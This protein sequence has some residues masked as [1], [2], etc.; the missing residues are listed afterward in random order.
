MQNT[1]QK[2]EKKQIPAAETG[3]GISL[4]KN[5]SL[6]SLKEEYINSA[7]MISGS[8]FI[9]AGSEFILNKT[10]EAAAA[11]YGMSLKTYAKSIDPVM[12]FLLY[13]MI[14]IHLIKSV[15]VSA[16][17]YN[18]GSAILSAGHDS[19]HAIDVTAIA[20]KDG[21]GDA[22][23][24]DIDNNMV[25]P[26]PVKILYDCLVA[27]EEI[28]DLYSPWRI[29]FGS[30]GMKRPVPNEW[31]KYP[32]EIYSDK[33]NHPEIYRMWQHRQHLHLRIRKK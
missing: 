6:E 13:E 5:I 16:T 3:P 22:F 10:A 19:G 17:Y 25:E 8:R 27:R 7:D 21:T 31:N 29:L 2:N 28:L 1:D 20:F 9:F 33:K 14:Q 23:F 24:R 18:L 32:L 12:I 30:G 11:K 26:T 15:T 4:L